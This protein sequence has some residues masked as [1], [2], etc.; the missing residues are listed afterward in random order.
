M[1]KVEEES[2]ESTSRRDVKHD[3]ILKWVSFI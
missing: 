1:D 2:V 3:H